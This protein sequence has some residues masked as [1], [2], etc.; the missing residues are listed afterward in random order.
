MHVI[1]EDMGSATVLIRPLNLS[2]VIYTGYY[3]G[4]SCLIFLPNDL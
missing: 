4:D 2:H 1:E 3:D